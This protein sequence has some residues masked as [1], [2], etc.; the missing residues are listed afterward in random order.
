M[1]MTE[2]WGRRM[3]HRD[4]HDPIH[5]PGHHTSHACGIEVITVTRHMPFDIGNAIKYVVRAEMKGGLEDLRKSEVYLT[6]YINHPPKF[7]WLS[8]R[9]AKWLRTFAEAEPDPIK[10]L[11]FEAMA[12]P[13]PEVARLHVREMISRAGG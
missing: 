9:Q 5:H 1:S 10:K 8:V 4:G 12:V 11:F 3:D 6:D 13:S 7:S 2:A